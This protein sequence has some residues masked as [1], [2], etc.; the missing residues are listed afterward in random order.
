M[1]NVTLHEYITDPSLPQKDGVNL[2][3]DNI[4]ELMRSQLHTGLKVLFHD[5]NRLLVDEGYA[6]Y[7]LEATDCV[8]SNVGPHAHYYFHLRDR[9]GLN[10]RIFRDVRTAIWSSYLLQEYLC[11]PFL[12]EEDVLM[13]GSHYTR[14]VYENLFPHL[15]GYPCLLC[16]PLTVNF[17]DKVPTRRQKTDEET[18]ILGYIG[19]LSE[20]KNFPDLVTL[21]I[22][23]NRTNTRKFKLLACGDVHSSSCAPDHIQSQV[24]DALGDGDFYEYLPARPHHEIWSLLTLFDVM[25]FPSTS[26][27][28][29]LGRVLI[30]ASY[31]GLPIVCGAHAAAPE[32]MPTTS[33]CQVT[34]DY[35][36][37]FSAHFDHRMGKIEISELAEKIVLGKLETSTCHE[38]FLEHPQKFIG[39]LLL[40]AA[41]ISAMDPLVLK[42]TQQALIEAIEV[43]L[44]PPLSADTAKPLIE[45]MT[46]WFLGLQN[47]DSPDY[48]ELV[49]RLLEK[50][51]YPQRT[52]SYLTKSALTRGDFTN[53]GGIDIELC[54]IARFYPQFSMKRKSS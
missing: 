39:A 17:P 33:L 30:E 41:E 27:L 54:H 42:P 10:Y 43:E 9:L 12:R 5:F 23:L 13:V 36:K 19:R 38:I 22:E 1:L 3:H 26:N 37:S 53:V 7:V 16:Y 35:D 32:L 40:G 11:A 25:L 49:L 18:F 14:G 8:I 48:P 2:A 46:A 4:C 50:T 45:T 21:L 52:Q 29:T 51:T 28:E 47:K 6:R 15:K 44:P 20:D 31:A 34:Y 24:K